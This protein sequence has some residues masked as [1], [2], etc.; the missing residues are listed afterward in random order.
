MSCLVWNCR[1]LGNPTAVRNLVWL[2]KH[3]TPI[4]VF[5]METKFISE[6]WVIFLRKFD[7]GFSFFVDS[8]LSHGGR[9]GGLGLLWND[10]LDITILSS[11]LHHINANVIDHSRGKVWRF[12]GIYGW[13]ERGNKHLT[14]QLMRHLKEEGENK[15][16]CA[17]DFNEVCFSS[18]KSGG[19]VSDW[20]RMEDFRSAI[21]E[22]GLFDLGYNGHKFTWSNN[23]EGSNHIEERLDRFLASYEWVT[24]FENY[25]VEHLLRKSSDHCP[26][27]LD[28]QPPLDT[29]KKKRIFFRL[30]AMW[31]KDQ[32]FMQVCRDAW[33]DQFMV[34]NN[35]GDFQLMVT[36]CGWKLKQW[37]K[38]NFG[39][40]SRQIRK[41]RDDL[42]GLMAVYNSVEIVDRKRSIEKEIDGLL[43]KEE[44]MWK[45]RSRA[46]WLHEGDRNTTYF[47]KVAN[48]R[49]RR[50]QINKITDSTGVIHSKHEEIELVFR[51]FF[52]ELFTSKGE[53]DMDE[54][55]SAVET[56]VTPAMN[57]VL[58]KP[59]SS[60]EI[61]EALSQMHPLKS[62][63][64]D[65]MP[66]LF[67]HKCWDFIKSDL[68][69]VLLDI[70]N[71]NGDH[72]PLNATHICLIPKKKNTIFPFD[73]RPISLC[74]VSYKVISKVIT[75]RLKKI[76]PDLIHINQSALSRAAK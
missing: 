51:H 59:Y 7:L 4:L 37:E 39:N 27:L 32:S 66:A 52:E 49:N 43:E 73:F 38:A 54:V 26:I 6:D 16:I 13:S 60:Q 47:H 25:A 46:L 50:N 19:A 45:Q 31:F 30:E 40:V 56:S 1:G 70:L 48:G 67:Y 20:S 9:R 55:L 33:L 35:P 34:P 8:D 65:G 3:K 42:N 57:E 18:K 44:I 53:N 61:V 23:Q 24:I 68:V 75:L 21:D 11:S 36:N 15:W 76:M 14:W 2:L 17:G 71:N 64:P 12:C 62:P 72:T 58:M 63:G 69:P 74:N 22:C 41:L 28:I 29:R 10:E 5:L